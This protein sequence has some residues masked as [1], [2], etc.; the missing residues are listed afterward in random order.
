[1][2]KTKENQWTGRAW[3]AAVML[4]ASTTMAQEAPGPSPAELSE[5]AMER[6][7]NVVLPPIKT[8]TLSPERR[9]AIEAT[10]DSARNRARDE[11]RRLA[12]QHP[13]TP[14]A[15]TPAADDQTGQ[16]P[17]ETIE[18]RVVVALSTSMP[19]SELRE[20]MA[21]L[22]GQPE[23]LVVLRGFVGGAQRVAPTGE[24]L[25]RVMR[26]EA[27]DPKS[28]RRRVD[29]VVDPLLY[30]AL[31]ID[32]V[33]AVVWLPGVSDVSHCDGEDFAAAVTVYG[34]VSVSYALQQINRHG[35][36]VPADLIKR[37]GG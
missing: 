20:Y 6:A 15:A 21:Q 30:R 16:R 36:D 7:R 12:E 18:G 19:E 14:E 32:R 37:F 10:A 33:P 35:G 2:G 31:A 23:A 28:R 9:K 22:D 1:M 34:T 4:A 13:F 3:A 5:A 17:P 27:G 8:P 25:D 26:K 24:A 29:V 11:L